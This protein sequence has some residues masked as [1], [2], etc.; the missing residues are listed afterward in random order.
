MSN[1]SDGLHR[2]FFQPPRTN[3]SGNFS[4]SLTNRKYSFPVESIRVQWI[5][6]TPSERLS[7]PTYN[8]SANYYKSLTNR[9]YTFPVESIRVQWI[10]YSWKDFSPIDFRFSDGK[11]GD[12]TGIY[13]TV[14]DNPLMLKQILL[15]STVRNEWRSAWRTCTLI[16]VWLMNYLFFPNI[17]TCFKITANKQNISLIN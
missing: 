13:L 16:L 10:T 14:L 3:M 1:G 6:W 15:T 11:H 17:S 7:T 4:K 2:N 5:R 8:M 9:E 12:T